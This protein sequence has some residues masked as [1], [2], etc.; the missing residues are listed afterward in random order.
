M[1][2]L[3]TYQQLLIDKIAVKVFTNALSAVNK[4]DCVP[5]IYQDDYE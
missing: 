1:L 3:N 4:T 5:C 2:K